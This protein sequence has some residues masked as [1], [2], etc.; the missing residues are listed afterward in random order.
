M[1]RESDR[2]RRAK[3]INAEVELQASERL[4]G[5]ANVMSVNPVAVQLSFPQT[6]FEV[7]SERSTTMVMLI[8]IDLLQP[9]FRRDVG[10]DEPTVTSNGRAVPADGRDE[11]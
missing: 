3:V 5:A 4:K 7:S 2:E 11:G 1:A 8:P 6:M 9:L 10:G